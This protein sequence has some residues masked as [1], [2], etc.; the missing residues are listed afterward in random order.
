MYK[1]VSTH[2]ERFPRGDLWSVGRPPLLR[3]ASW[4]GFWTTI[5]FCG[6]AAAEFNVVPVI[7]ADSNVMEAAPNVPPAQSR[8]LGRWEGPL[9][10]HKGQIP[11]ALVVERMKI[12]GATV[13]WSTGDTAV[14]NAQVLRVDALMKSEDEMSVPTVGRPMTYRLNSDGT[15]SAVFTYYG[16]ELW[17]TMKKVAGPT[18]PY[19]QENEETHWP[20][21]ISGL[22]YVQKTNSPVKAVLPNDLQFAPVSAVPPERAPWMGKWGG[23]IC[24]N[25]FCDAKLAVLNVVGD[26]ATVFPILARGDRIRV[27]GTHTAQFVGNE[28]R[29]ITS[30]SNRLT[31]RMRYTNTLEV[32]GLSANGSVVVWGVLAR[33]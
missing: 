30:Y 14:T 12:K 18:L 29:V 28:L 24:S 11:H 31:Y 15:L 33:E 5:L 1:H 19:A 3:I 21:G 9:I 26:T 20:A 7:P 22:S 4:L 16:V 32:Y 2:S 6:Q 10:G 13:L 27:T 25:A 8:F 23:A 17:G